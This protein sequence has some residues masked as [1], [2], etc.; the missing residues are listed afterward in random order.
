MLQI[1]K[2][3]TIIASTF[4]PT[5]YDNTLIQFILTHHYLRFGDDLFLQINGIAM[6]TYM[7][8]QYANISMDDL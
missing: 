8:S 4:I 2:H 3:A 5:E 1:I 7:A 6:G